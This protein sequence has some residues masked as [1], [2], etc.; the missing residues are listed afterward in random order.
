VLW[1]PKDPKI[2]EGK[3]S[4][5]WTSSFWVKKAFINNI[6]QL[7]TLNNENITL[8]NV[9]KLKAYRNP[10]IKVGAITIITQDENRILPNKI[11]RRIINE[12]WTNFN[13]C[14]KFNKCR[15]KA[16][17]N[18]NYGGNIIVALPRKW[19]RDHKQ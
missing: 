17:H 4:F 8:V 11:P 5:P 14:F 2:K 9:N 18:K 10:I 19:I 1:L 7:N 3:F 6:V 12:R 16:Q 15:G 13:E